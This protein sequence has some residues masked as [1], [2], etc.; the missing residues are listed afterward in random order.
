[1]GR[2]L[3]GHD[4]DLLTCVSARLRLVPGARE[5]FHQQ[6]SPKPKGSRAACAA[7]RFSARPSASTTVLVD[8][9]AV[10]GFHS[11]GHACR[12]ADGT[13]PQQLVRGVPRCD[14]VPAARDVLAAA[15]HVGIVLMTVDSIDESAA[16]FSERCGWA[17]ALA[18]VVVSLM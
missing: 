7:N 10:V 1:M 8:D 11:H 13:A 2:E 3:A 6:R 14:A 9:G 17:C 5:L 18:A 4:G 15:E 16:A 12:R